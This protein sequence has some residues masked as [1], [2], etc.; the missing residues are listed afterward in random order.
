[1]TLSN[2]PIQVIWWKEGTQNQSGSVLTGQCPVFPADYRKD[3]VLTGQG[4]CSLKQLLVSF[5][6]QG[7][8][9]I[10]SGDFLYPTSER[11]SDGVS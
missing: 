5:D 11:M 6:S 1:M 8:V 10:F 3:L 7:Q 4:L 2:H 9:G